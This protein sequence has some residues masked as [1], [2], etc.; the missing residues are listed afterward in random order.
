MVDISNSQYGA[1][2][3][4]PFTVTGSITSGSSTFSATGTSAFINGDGIAIV[5]AGA[6]VTLTT[7]GTPTVTPSL[8]S[9]PINT[10][11]TVASAAGTGTASYEIVALDNYGGYTAASAAGS[12]SI[13]QTLGANTVTGCTATRS[14]NVVTI[15]NCSAAAVLKAGTRV[16]ISTTTDY[17]FGGFFTVASITNSTTFVLNTSGEDTRAGGE[18]SGTTQTVSV[19]YWACNHVA[20]SASTGGTVSAYL[21]YEYNGTTYQY[22]YTTFPSVLGFNTV[23]FDDYG[24]TMMA[25]AV[26]PWWASTSAPSSAQND[27]LDTTIVSG[28]GTTSMV[29][30]ATSSATFTCPS[31]CA[32]AYID[33]SPGLKA[34]LTQAATTG[35]SPIYIPASTTTSGFTFMTPVTLSDAVV[36]QAGNITLETTLT[37]TGTTKWFGHYDYGWGSEAPQFSAFSSPII[38]VTHGA[39][40]GILVSGGSF[41]LEGVQMTS[42]V[43][44]GDLALAIVNTT[45]YELNH[46]NFSIGVN[47]DTDYMGTNVVIAN[48]SGGGG[49]RPNLISNIELIQFG[50][51]YGVG[52]PQL[53]FYECGN[54]ASITQVIAAGNGMFVNDCAGEFRFTDLYWQGGAVPMI[55]HYQYPISQASFD[56]IQAF[57]DTSAAAI[58]E[59][60]AP[61]SERVNIVDSGGAANQDL[62][63]G[64]PITDLRIETGPNSAVY[65]TG[66]YSYVGQNYNLSNCVEGQESYSY[67]YLNADPTVSGTPPYTAVCTDMRIKEFNGLNSLGWLVQPPAISSVTAA[68]GGTFPTGTYKFYVSAVSSS[69]CTAATYCASTTLSAPT[70]LTISSGSQTITVSYAAPV[71]SAGQTPPNIAYNVWAQTAGGYVQLVSGCKEITTLSCTVSSFSPLTNNENPT[72]GTL[73][74]PSLNAQGLV[75]PNVTNGASVADIQVTIAAATF[76]SN[77]CTSPSTT[78]MPNLTA[79]MVPNWGPSTNFSNIAGWG[80]T[81]GLTIFSWPTANTLNYSVCNQTGSSITPSAS[82]TFNVAA[83]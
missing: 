7:P 82:V 62:V 29:L 42:G 83:R 3:V 33:A 55:S 5:G 39:K 50:M 37:S 19:T 45:A 78:S 16:Q 22:W 47:G 56:I 34:A 54:P 36:R 74:Y 1:R 27:F 65:G 35:G 10:G 18:G 4:S 63:T 46:D 57:Y 25:N 6:T 66:P 76:T 64:R 38:K 8:A 77:A 15:S 48:P 53:I 23:S 13:A 17:T 21:I 11:M 68:S 58:Y 59:E 30:A 70:P 72:I 9:G 80:S 2:A 69:G 40:P 43:G 51:Q 60:L 67:L 32:T 24:T 26:A 49:S 79:T 73:L 14:N 44:N 75:A 31:T 28:G 20:W 61:Y 71:N 81:G 41:T 52:T 12:T